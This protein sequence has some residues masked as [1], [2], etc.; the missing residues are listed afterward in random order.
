MFVDIQ[1]EELM[2]ISRV[3]MILAKCSRSVRGIHT[4]DFSLL[5]SFSANC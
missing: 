4:L 5:E 1:I 3:L 2:V